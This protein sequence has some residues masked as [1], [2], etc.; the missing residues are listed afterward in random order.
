MDDQQET[1]IDKFIKEKPKLNNL[2]EAEGYI[3]KL[4]DVLKM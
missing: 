3:D 2:R 1:L 4:R